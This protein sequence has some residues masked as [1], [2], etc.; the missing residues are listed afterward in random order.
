MKNSLPK[1]IGLFALIAFQSL[2]VAGQQKN[3]QLREKILLEKYETQKQNDNAVVD[4][5]AIS[6]NAQIKKLRQLSKTSNEK[7]SAKSGNNNLLEALLHKCATVEMNDRLRANHPGMATKEQFEQWMSKGIKARQARQAGQKTAAEVVTLPVI[8]HIMHKGEAVGSGMNIPAAQVASQLKVLNADFRR[9]N[10]DRIQTP[11]FFAGVAADL[12]IEF[13]LATVDPDGVPLS[14][15]GIRRMQAPAHDGPWTPEEI[16]DMI[17]PNTIW[18]PERYLNIWVIDLGGD[19]LGFATFPTA[20]GLE[21]LNFVAPPANTEGVVLRTTAFGSNFTGDGTFNLIPGSDRG[22]TTTHEIGHFLGLRHVWGDGDCSQ[23]DFCNDTPNASQE[24]FVALPNCGQGA[25]SCDDGVGDLPDMVQ[26]YMD[27]SFDGCMNLFTADQKNR[28]RTVLDLSPRRKEL[29]SSTTS[30]PTDPDGV[31]AG[32]DIST[33]RICQGESVSFSDASDAGDNTTI[34][35]WAWDFDVA[36]I[37]GT[38]ISTGA[39]QGPFSV[40]YTMAGEFEI[41]LTVTGANSAT[42]VITKTVVVESSEVTGSI[43]ESQG[44]EEDFPPTNWGIVNEGFITWSQVSVG[45]RGSD[46]AVFI[47]NFTNNLSGLTNITLTTPTYDLSGESSAFLY[48]DV[49]YAGF[50]DENN[51]NAEVFDDLAI[52]YSTNCGIDFTELTT[53]TGEQLASAP[54]VAGVFIPDTPEKWKNMQVDLSSFAGILDEESIVFGF[55]NRGNFGNLIFIDNVVISSAVDQLPSVANN[56][57]DIAVFVNS[58]DTVFSIADVFTDEDNDDNLI[59][60]VV[61]DNTN[62]GLVSTNLTG[63]DL[64]LGFTPDAFGSSIITLQATSNGLVTTEKFIVRVLSDFDILVNQNFL[65]GVGVTNSEFSDLEGTI[66]N[67]DDFTIPEG[68]IYTINEVFV[69]GFFTQGSSEP[70]T[71]IKLQFFEDDNGVPGTEVFSE[72]SDLSGT[73][74]L[75]DTAY[76]FPLTM[77]LEL[78]E[79]TYWMSLVPVMNSTTGRWNWLETNSDNGAAFHLIDADNLFNAGFTDWTPSTSII[80]RKSDLAFEIRGTISGEI[81]PLAPSNLQATTISSNQ[82]DLTWDDNSNNETGFTI[83]RSEV[84]TGPFVE[85]GSVPIDINTFSDNTFTPESDCEVY[86]YRVVANRLPADSGPSNLTAAAV[87][88]NTITPFQ[89]FTEGFEGDFPPAGWEIFNFANGDIGWT[90]TNVGVG[91]NSANSMFIDNFNNDLTTQAPTIINTPSFDLRGLDGLFLSFD[92]A[93]VGFA[94]ANA[95]NFDDLLIGYSVDCGLTDSVFVVLQGEDIATGDPSGEIFSPSGDTNW[96]KITLNMSEL[97]ESDSAGN[98]RLAFVNLPSFGQPI[99]IDNVSMTEGLNIAAPSNLAGTSS[100]GTTINLTWNDNADNE[101][102]Q[103]IERSENTQD[104]FVE[105]D[106]VASD[107][108]GYNDTDLQEEITYFYRVRGFN[109]PAFSDYSNVAEV[110]VEPLG[111]SEKLQK[112]IKIYPNPSNG[113]MTLSVDGYQSQE[114]EIKLFNNLGKLI[115]A[116][117]Y[118]LERKRTTINLDISTR[119]PGIYLLQVKTTDGFA[120]KRIIK[121]N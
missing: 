46:N 47:N 57:D 85:V 54:P 93:Y 63:D 98:I 119:T 49:A 32:F 44:F 42:D 38:S 48:F 55:S 92:V 74:S 108:T 56:L 4:K 61:L 84:E 104:N 109:G 24:N 99:H 82:V 100:R 72:S 113:V 9:L 67:A 95:N 69:P 12:E 107:V 22:R 101:A 88:M 103:I 43:P 21:G 37:G 62:T 6:N 23:D 70:P 79:G 1:L 121:R 34:N 41:S 20:S 89:D 40:Q 7:I 50:I 45:A 28:I 87:A 115:S 13:A 75:T 8:V 65:T 14:E 11:S 86:F 111:I 19:V 64:T 18:D 73:L 96:Q 120:A 35:A 80:N 94:G 30:Q 78:T 77:P 112:A 60:V 16:D 114:L 59:D 33:V 106:T 105:I 83:F 2:H 52:V 36:S 5:N 31:F 10:E 3:E 68:A 117:G 102:N 29:T 27:F 66:Q 15:V 58:A 25:N 26:N 81:P 110:F 118:G 53:F 91:E 116:D 97:V 39:T 90:K 71:A 17:K 76:V 51:G